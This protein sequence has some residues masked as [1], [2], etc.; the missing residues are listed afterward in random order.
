M[1][2][3]KI[4]IVDV[5]P[6]DGLQNDSTPVST[7]DKIAL[8]KLLI[9]AGIRKI[10][11]A[12]FVNPKL[13]PQMADA[14]ELVASLPTIDGITYIGLVL[15]DRG[16]VRALETRA[17][18]GGINQVGCVA[19]P[20]DT[21]AMKNQR[22]TSKETIAVAKEILNKARVEGMS[23]QVTISSACGCPF[24]G[25]VPLSKIVDIAKEVAEAEPVEIAIADTI[26]VGVPSQVFDIF[27]AVAEA[28][29][30]IPLRGHFHNTRNTGIANV[31]SAIKAGAL[32]IDASIG[33]L[34]GCPFAPKATG[35]VATEDVIYMLE[36]S[37]IETGVNLQ[38]LIDT[39]VWL[40][41]VL[42]R[43]LPGMLARAGNFPQDTSLA[44]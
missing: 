27:S 43:Q 10:E 13:V 30:H 38:K 3:K 44:L 24:E 34:G 14:E 9:D 40:Q 35:N 25:E 1:N 36:R 11:V 7:T 4:S 17:N 8:I 37:N 26:G 32:T 20:S 2:K 28:V 42:N 21:F 15:N 6:R 12:S 31:W 23:A 5:G 41:S 16:F 39:N 33:G 19:L 29:P 22:Q 18:G